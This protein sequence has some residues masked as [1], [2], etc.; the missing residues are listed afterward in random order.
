MGKEQTI[1]FALL[2]VVC[3][4]LG[5]A[6]G[7]FV[8]RDNPNPCEI[9]EMTYYYSEYYGRSECQRV[10]EDGTILKLKDLGITVVEIEIKT[11]ADRVKYN[12]QRVPTFEIEGERYPGYMTFEQLKSLLKC[13]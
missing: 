6:I 3:F 13:Y 10:K 8:I 2:I 7:Y 12:L 9:T 1:A 4:I 5:G 11:E